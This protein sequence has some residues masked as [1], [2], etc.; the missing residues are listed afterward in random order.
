MT[1]ISFIIAAAALFL[2]G[3]SY[4]FRLP[5]RSISLTIAGLA[6]LGISASSIFVPLLAEIVESI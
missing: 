2:F 1:Q 6:L 4:V 3:P 5:A